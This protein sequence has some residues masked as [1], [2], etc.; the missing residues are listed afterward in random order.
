VVGQPNPTGALPDP[1]EVS[2]AL[3]GGKGAKGR[4]QLV[5]Q[6]NGQQPSP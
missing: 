3:L 5:V 6:N 2:A 4:H 1:V